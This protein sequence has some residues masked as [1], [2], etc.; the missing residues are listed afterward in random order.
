MTSNH[1]PT[2]ERVWIHYI[3]ILLGRRPLSK[4]MCPN[5]HSECL[6]MV[7]RRV[8][9]RKQSLSVPETSH[10]ETW[11]ELS[12]IQSPDCKVIAWGFYHFPFSLHS[13]SSEWIY[14]VPYSAHITMFVKIMN[15][16]KIWVSNTANELWKWVLNYFL[17]LLTYPPASTLP[18]SQKPNRCQE[19]VW[20][21]SKAKIRIL[22][23]SVWYGHFFHLHHIVDCKILGSHSCD[24]WEEKNSIKLIGNTF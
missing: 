21:V 3:E 6:E 5:P 4:W 22:K 11:W 15:S 9:Y 24:K 2:E 19:E 1:C 14:V 16:L 18:F 13:L 20:E 17:V 23:R 12:F 7:P 8:S 10:R